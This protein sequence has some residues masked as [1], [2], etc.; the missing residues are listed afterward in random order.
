MIILEKTG[1][2]ILPHDEAILPQ[3]IGRL[4]LC[5]MLGARLVH[6]GFKVELWPAKMGWLSLATLIMILRIGVGHEV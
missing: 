4:L 2:S 5:T 1:I 6:H 3:M